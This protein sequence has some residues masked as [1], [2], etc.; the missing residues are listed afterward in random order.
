V[1][2]FRSIAMD[3][4]EFAGMWESA[5]LP[6]GTGDFYLSWV[7]IIQG[8]ARGGGSDA[9]ESGGGKKRLLDRDGACTALNHAGEDANW[10]IMHR[11]TG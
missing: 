1:L 10:K 9:K 5:L 3:G 2:L 11:I 8:G 6:R 7:V 4:L